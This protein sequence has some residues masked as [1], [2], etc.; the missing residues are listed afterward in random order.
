MYKKC[1]IIL[2]ICIVL[3]G[4]LWIFMKKSSL[5]E[6]SQKSIFS[7]SVSDLE[8]IVDTFREMEASEDELGYVDKHETIAIRV[9]KEN[10]FFSPKM[11]RVNYQ[12]IQKENRIVLDEND[13]DILCCIVEAEAGGEDY[14]GKKLVAEVVLNRVESAKFPNTVEEVVFQQEDGVYQFSP[15]AD[16]RFYRVTVSEETKQAVDA[17]LTGEDES[18][19]ALYF[20]NRKYSSTKALWWFDN[21]CT[22]LF[23]YGGHEFFS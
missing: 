16:G 19:G 20:I 13:Y 9:S 17:A 23:F 11:H 18:R 2:Y 14:L 15:V 22:P 4:F 10:E 1:S 8:E 12:V 3:I 7:Y 5:N 21:R 6:A